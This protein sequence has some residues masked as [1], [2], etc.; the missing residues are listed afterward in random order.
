MNGSQNIEYCL[1]SLK[2]IFTDVKNTMCVPQIV[3]EPSNGES[4]NYLNHIS[5]LSIFLN[6]DFYNKKNSYSVLNCL[7]K[8]NLK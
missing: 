1:E 5:Y 4:G 6:E 3:S 8:K 2:D 7:L